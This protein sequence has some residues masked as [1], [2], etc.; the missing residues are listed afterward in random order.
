[1]S[2]NILLM[3]VVMLKERTNIHGNLDEK[4]VYPDIKYAQ[5]VYIFPLLG[6]A[7]FAKLQTII[8]DNT[9][10]TDSS[11]ADYKNL[12]DVYIIDTLT[13]YIL[14][15]LPISLGFQFWNRGVTRK[16]GLDSELP[17]M[18]ELV[19]L[20]NRYKNRAEYYA[21]RLKAYLCANASTKFPEYLNPGSSTDT[22][23]PDQKTF[24]LPI[25]LGDTDDNKRHWSNNQPYSE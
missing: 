19:D 13:Y 24:T 6:T 1:M 4:L 22:V 2:A 15:E 11:K 16:G 8:A 10:K 25:Y 18:S 5:D 17:T 9:I 14:S 20:Q 23:V 3:D 12:L 21:N 7:L